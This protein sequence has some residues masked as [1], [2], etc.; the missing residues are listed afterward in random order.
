MAALVGCFSLPLGGPRLP[1]AKELA[2][3]FESFPIGTPLSVIRDTRPGLFP[4][5]AQL[6]AAR[7]AVLPWVVYNAGADSINCLYRLYPRD[8]LLTTARD[9][10]QVA[11]FPVR[12]TLAYDCPD[13]VVE[14]LLSADGRYKGYY[15]YSS[16]SYSRDSKERLQAERE[17]H[18]RVLQ[19]LAPDVR[20]GLGQR[21]AVGGQ[22][23]R[24]HLPH[25]P[26]RLPE[27]S[28]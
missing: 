5:E 22:Q 23:G 1:T 12:E 18:R 13:G 20:S 4:G 17:Y 15:A 21:W 25:L 10:D 14:V 24:E 26:L 27:P 2:D 11:R 6:V 8:V 9:D 28:P 16:C 19:A 7:D 3:H